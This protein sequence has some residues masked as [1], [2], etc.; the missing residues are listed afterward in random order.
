[1]SE[2][3]T[4]S[5]AFMTGLNTLVEECPES[6]D[7]TSI[8]YKQALNGLEQTMPGTKIGFLKGFFKN[9]NNYFSGA[10]K[11]PEELKPCE[12]CGYLTVAGLCSVCRIRQKV[13][14]SPAQQLKQ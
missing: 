8:T 9:R 2:Y 3:E 1:M 4:A 10:E 7:A 14:G 11:N 13:A 12:T 5:Y 6:K